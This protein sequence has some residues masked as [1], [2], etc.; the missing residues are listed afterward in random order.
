MRGTGQFHRIK[1]LFL[2]FHQP[3]IRGQCRKPNRQLIWG[4]FGTSIC[5]S[6]GRLWTVY[7][8]AS[9]SWISRTTNDYPN[10]HPS[11]TSKHNSNNFH[12]HILIHRMHRSISP[13][14]SPPPKTSQKRDFRFFHHET[15]RIPEISLG[16]GLLMKGSSN[17]HRV[18]A[19]PSG[20]HRVRSPICGP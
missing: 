11:F 19:D 13:K 5:R 9:H 15:M 1:T 4:W 2:L 17:H 3:A 18:R 6:G 8:I 12:T 7:H 14:S 20:H 10:V 16:G